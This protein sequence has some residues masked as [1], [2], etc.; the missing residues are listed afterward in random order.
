MKEIIEGILKELRVKYI[1]ENDIEKI[2]STNVVLYW[3]IE[4]KSKLEGF[5][6]EFLMSR[7]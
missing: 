4:D 1:T 5:K 2:E 3:N 7:I 6:C